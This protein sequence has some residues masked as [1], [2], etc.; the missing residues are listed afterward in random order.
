MSVK[1]KLL[2]PSSTGADISGHFATVLYNGDGTMSNA[3][4]G[5]GFQPDFLFIK[6]RNANSVKPVIVDSIRG[7]NSILMTN[8]SNA[9]QTGTY[10]YY[11]GGVVSFDSDGFTVKE[12]VYPL[13]AKSN[14]NENGY[15]Y[16]AW[17]FNAGNTSATNTDGTINTTV[18]ANND[19][20]FSIATYTGVGYPNST[21]AEIGHGLDSAPEMVIIK[22]YGGSGQSGGAGSWVVGSSLLGSGWDGGMYLNSTGAYYNA[23]NYFWNGAATSSVIKLKNDWFVN[24]ANN[25]YVAYS[26]TSIDGISKVGTY[27]GN[28]SAGHKITTDFEV[29]FI[30][31]KCSSHGLSGT[32]FND[33]SWFIWD[34]QRGSY[35]EFPNKDVDQ[36]SASYITFDSDGFTLSS[37]SFVNASGRE[38][39]Y[40]VLAA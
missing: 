38:Y 18:R 11:Y 34:N 29:G 35:A 23:V 7:V 16:V 6:L 21:T 19:L 5:V 10:I 30:L 24:G 32:D 37:A 25:N 33:T 17:C 27:T 1:Q 40:Y 8:V 12:A 26:F 14:F 22:G 36:A 13:S 28:G 20:G 15:N 9:A 31:G 4:T 39:I 3:I 2:L